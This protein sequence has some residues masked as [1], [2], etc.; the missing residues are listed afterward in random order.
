MAHA[1]GTLWMIGAALAGSDRYWRIARGYDRMGNA[2]TGG[3]DTETVSSRAS[4]AR[5]EG[6]TWGCVLCRVLDWIEKDHCSRSE[7]T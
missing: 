6:R 4:R 7:G 5:R 3:L 1:I 2:V